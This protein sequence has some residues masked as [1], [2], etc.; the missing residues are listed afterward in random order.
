LNTTAPESAIVLASGAISSGVPVIQPP[1]WK[2]TTVGPSLPYTSRLSVEVKG[3]WRAAARVVVGAVVVVGGRVAVVGGS[4]VD[5]VDLAAVVVVVV[6]AVVTVVDGIAALVQAV[7]VTV[8]RST[9][10]FTGSGA[11]RFDLATTQ[12]G[13]VHEVVGGEH[14]HDGRSGPILRRRYPRSVRDIVIEWGDD[15]TVTGRLVEGD[16]LPAVLLA[17]GAGAGQDH[18]LVALLRDGLAAHG[19][20]VVTFEYSYMAEGRRRPDRTSTLIAVHEAALDWVREHLTEHVVLAGR[21]MGGRIA[22]LLAEGADAEGLICYS[23][24]LHPPGRP[25]RLRAE[26]LWRVQVPMLFFVGE[27]D[28][29]ARHELVDAYLRP[30]PRATVEVVDGADHSLRT[31]KRSG[32]TTEQVIERIVESSAEWIEGLGE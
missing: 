6:V 25:D 23:Y 20:P 27:R 8:M 21:S 4:V 10:R 30:L 24:P 5:V 2:R 11:P 13:L 12:F 32:V 9:S 26:H 22:S 28:A 7:T 15:R 1:P 19:Y 31:L 29:F 14:A 16:L 18:P 3:T 17:H